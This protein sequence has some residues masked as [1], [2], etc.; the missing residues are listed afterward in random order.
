MW[1]Q[2]TK[3]EYPEAFTKAKVLEIGSYS[4]NGTARDY[5]E[6]DCTYV[7][8]DIMAGPEV[9]IVAPALETKFKEGE[10]DVLLSVCMFEHD[11]DWKKTITH[12]KQ[13][14]KQGGLF[15]TSLGAE[16][17]HIHLYP[18]FVEI[19]SQEFI[20]FVKSEGFEVLSSFFEHEQ[21]NDQGVPNP[22]GIFDVVLRKL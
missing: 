19:Q 11:P 4:V 6:K 17:C 15:I 14:L 8:V 12:N 22:S 10:F 21:F 16:G 3:A 18:V 13:W 1:I 5:F 2:K 20:D 7:G 9:D